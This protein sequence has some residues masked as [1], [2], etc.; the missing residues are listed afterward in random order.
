MHYECKPIGHSIYG[1]FLRHL[2]IRF[3]EVA[4]GYSVLYEKYKND[5][6]KLLLVGD[7]TTREYQELSS[8]TSSQ[9]QETNATSNLYDTPKTNLPNPLNHPS[10]V[11]TNDGTGKIDTSNTGS[12]NRNET[13][14]KTSAGYA[15]EV[16]KLRENYLNLDNA[17][18]E[19]FKNLFLG[20]TILW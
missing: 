19:E 6:D 20:I 10:S 9:S 16:N 8:L 17:F 5:A 13:E 14:Q 2:R 4:M 15:E 12:I 1:E 18:V 3:N 7:V 11:N